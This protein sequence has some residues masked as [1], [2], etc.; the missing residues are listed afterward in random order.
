MAGQVEASAKTNEIPM[1]IPLPGGLDLR[2]SVITADA[3]YRRVSWGRV[4][5]PG[6]AQRSRVVVGLVVRRPGGG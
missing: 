3:M 5:A 2:G 6:G 1:I 4:A